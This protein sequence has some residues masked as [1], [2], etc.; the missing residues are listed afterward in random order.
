MK[1]IMPYNYNNNSPNRSI[2]I[3][4]NDVRIQ[5]NLTINYFP[6]DKATC[7]RIYQP[8]TEF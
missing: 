3:I 8:F 6:Y 5:Y 4:I 7:L 2:K 1:V